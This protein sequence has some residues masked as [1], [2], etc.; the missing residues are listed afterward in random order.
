MSKIKL[1]GALTFI[2]S[3]ILAFISLNIA[4]KNRKNIIIFSSLTKQKASI[5]EISKSIFYSYRNGVPTPQYLDKTIEGITVG[6]SEI[7]LIKN[8][9]HHFYDDVKNFR[10]QQKIATGYNPIITAKLVNRIYHN[11]V[12]LV[13]ELEKL[14]EAK[15]FNTQQEIESNKSL[16]NTLFFLLI[17]LLFYLFTQLHLVLKFIHKFSKTSKKIIKNSTIQGVEPINIKANIPQL[18]EATEGYNQMVKKM[19][20]SIKNSSNSMTQSIKSLEEVAQNIEIFMEFL[21]TMQDKKSDE[22]FEKEDAVIDS[23]EMLMRLRKKLKDLKIELD[24]LH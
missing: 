15:Q 13:A 5:E 2:L 11:N 8:L 17:S 16:Q 18:K 10:I 4:N 19:N 20:L 21:S 7:I 1:V 9:W 12:L 14:I 23:L 3:L 22:L 24:K 6:E